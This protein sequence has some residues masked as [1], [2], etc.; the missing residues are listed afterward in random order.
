MLNVAPKSCAPAMSR[1]VERRDAFDRQLADV[2]AQGTSHSEI[3]IRA[4][5]SV[6]ASVARPEPLLVT[7]ACARGDDAIRIASLEPG[8]AMAA[9]KRGAEFTPAVLA[10]IQA[11]ALRLMLEVETQRKRLN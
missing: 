1:T 6:C 4:D 10:H 2:S 3:R 9:L 7:L 5:C 11:E 8:D